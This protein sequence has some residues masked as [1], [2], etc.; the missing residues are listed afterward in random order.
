MRERPVILG[1][2]VIIGIGLLASSFLAIGR[3]DSYNTQLTIGNSIVRVEVAR[4]FFEKYRGLSERELMCGDCGM[5]FLFE[6]AD[7]LDFV[8]RQMK[9]PLDFVFIIDNKVS[10]IYENI[11]V[12]QNSESPQRVSS[13]GDADAVVEVNA[14]FIRQSGIEVGDDVTID[15]KQ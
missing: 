14:G 7:R 4:T 1:L 12:P 6:K 9:F 2:I 11:P 13:L 15:S 10:E 5:I 3:T 8:M